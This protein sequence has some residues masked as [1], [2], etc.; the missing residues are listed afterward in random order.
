MAA[1]SLRELRVAVVERARGQ[2]EYCQKPDD[3]A[4]NLY[5][6]EVDHIIAEKHGGKLELTNLAYAC[7]QC[8]R[9]KGSDIASIDP[10]GGEVVQLFNPR[11][12]NW[13]G[14][15]QLNSDGTITALTPEGRTTVTLLRFNDPL[16]AQIRADLIAVGKLRPTEGQ[17]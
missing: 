11:T 15:F 4:L 7:F 16:R 9:H 8:N 6:H 3:Q 10:Q 13:E 12:Q 2:C 14:H 1:E 5:R 17:F